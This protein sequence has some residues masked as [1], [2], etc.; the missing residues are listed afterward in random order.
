MLTK[1]LFYSLVLSHHISILILMVTPVFTMINEPFWVWF[2][3]NV[4]V[5]HLMFSPVLVCPATVWENRLRR[6]LGKEEIKTFFLHYYIKPLKRIW[7]YPV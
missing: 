2:P 3:I 5:M 6:K 4:W 7:K 1:L